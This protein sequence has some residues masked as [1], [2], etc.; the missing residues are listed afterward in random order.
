MKFTDLKIPKCN[1]VDM[2][3]LKATP[4]KRKDKL[5]SIARRYNHNIIVRK[6]KFHHPVLQIVERNI[7]LCDYVSNILKHKKT[8]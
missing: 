5:R 6:S 2:V 3:Y 1:E 7:L 8:V 4:K